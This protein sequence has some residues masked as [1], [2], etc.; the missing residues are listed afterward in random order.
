M[1]KRAL[2]ALLSILLMCLVGILLWFTTKMHD[3]TTLEKWAFATSFL[4]IGLGLGWILFG[5]LLIYAVVPRIDRIV[6]ADAPSMISHTTD[7]LFFRVHRL[8]MYSFA[9][10]SR[11]GNMR[12]H[13]EF[14]FSSL[15]PELKAPMR[16]FYYWLA[17]G[18][19]TMAFSYVLSYWV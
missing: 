15:Q 6:D 3:Y 8:L 19:L 13:P 10:S 2:F 9:A 16:A 18:V 4:A 14:D 12:V 17:L 11:W 7:P 1:N 5:I